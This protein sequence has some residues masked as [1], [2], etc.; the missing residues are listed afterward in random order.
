MA[1]K[2]GNADYE[3][4]MADLAPSL[5][6][7]CLP[8]VWRKFVESGKHVLFGTALN[9]LLVAVPMAILSSY[10][11]IGNVSIQ[12]V[13]PLTSPLLDPVFFHALWNALGF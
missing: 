4:T 7:L 6:T 5:P 8:S 12:L 11:H 3:K 2:N 13:R 9:V 10:L 1:M